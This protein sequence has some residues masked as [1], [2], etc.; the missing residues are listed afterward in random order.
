M[1]IEVG[2]EITSY[3]VTSVSV[4]KMK[5]MATLLADPN[6]F[7][8]DARAT[9]ELGMGDRP[10]NQGPLNMECVMTMLSNWAGTESRTSGSAS[11]TTS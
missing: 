11:S 10:V 7:H 9:A 3:D 8:W 4:E 2:P 1:T 6:L 5:T